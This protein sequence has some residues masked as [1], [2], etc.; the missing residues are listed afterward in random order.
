MA[1][2]GEGA[3]NYRILCDV[4]AC[5]ADPDFRPDFD[6]DAEHE[7]IIRRYRE[8]FTDFRNVQLDVQSGTFRARCIQAENLLAYLCNYLDTYGTIRYDQYLELSRILKEL[9]DY[10]GDVED[11]ADL[12]GAL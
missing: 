10:V 7:R 11:V 4:I 8:V 9:T 1:Y 12:F 2:E 6:W 5:L 3:R